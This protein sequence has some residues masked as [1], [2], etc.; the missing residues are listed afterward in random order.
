MI[1]RTDQDLVD[2][3][4]DKLQRTPKRRSDDDLVRQIREDDDDRKGSTQ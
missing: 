1:D 4:A 3:I 2:A